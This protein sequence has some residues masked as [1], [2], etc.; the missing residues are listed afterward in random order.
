MP[1]TLQL[2]H[3]LSDYAF[4]VAQDEQ[5]VIELANLLA[6]VVETGAKKITYALFNEE[7]TFQVYNAARGLSAKSQRILFGA[8]TAN[9]D[10]QTNGLEIPIDDQ[11]MPEAAGAKTALE[12]AKVKTL[13]TTSYNSHLASVVAIA[14]AGVNVVAKIGNWS[15][16]NVDPIAELDAQLVEISRYR[17]P[18]C[19]IMD[20]GAW[21]IAKNNPLVTKR[22]IAA[23][24]TLEMFASQLVVPGI[25]IE[26]TSVAFNTLGFA[27]AAQAKKG[28][29]GSEV[30]ITCNSPA[31]SLFDPS[32]MKTFS[33]SGNLFGGVRQYRDETVH[34]EI[35]DLD[36][37]AMPV[38][39]STKLVRRIGVS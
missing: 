19:I 11:E 7:N 34:S 23:G 38:V 26:L 27:N 24:F 32:F 3:D 2:R 15:D 36:W 21:L 39:V 35:Y 33:V 30:W 28:A 13:V 22:F 12:Q 18:T 16:P 10:L 6:P 5:K 14:K 29:L 8:D 1:P 37:H 25:K 31:P 9:A 20:V 17:T 4:G